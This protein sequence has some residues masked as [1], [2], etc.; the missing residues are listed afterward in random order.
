ML[1]RFIGT[2]SCLLRTVGGPGTR[3]CPGLMRRTRRPTLVSRDATD[4]PQRPELV[5]PGDDS[6]R[7][8]I[9][10][11]DL[12]ETEETSARPNG[13]WNAVSGRGRNPLRCPHNPKVAGSN[14]APATNRRRRKSPSTKQR[15]SKEGLCVC[16][17][18]RRSALATTHRSPE[19]ERTSAPCCLVAWSVAVVPIWFRF[20]VGLSRRAG[21][22]FRKEAFQLA[23]PIDQSLRLRVR[24]R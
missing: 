19:L 18:L 9:R 6:V 15:P 2:S 12:S 8:S 17:G 10:G 7:G 22:R 3:R 1:S 14:P 13:P 21:S 24:H 23:Q 20:P 4:T 11:S 16:A 5:G